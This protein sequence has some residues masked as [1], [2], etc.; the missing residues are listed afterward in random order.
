MD[1]PKMSAVDLT[2]MLPVDTAVLQIYRPGTN[3]PIGWE[4]TMAGPAHAK[5]VE[6]NNNAA[7]KASHR[8]MLMEQARVNNRKWKGEDKQPEERRREFIEGIVARIVTWTPVQI[9]STVYEF[10][11]KSA[12]ELLLKPEMG[13]FVA[14]AVDFLIDE[15]AFT[16]DSEKP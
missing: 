15:R 8:D 13:A 10:S 11:E 16:K 1:T 9:G 6:F 7:R 4:W 2:G 12:V 3:E 14:Q 5:T